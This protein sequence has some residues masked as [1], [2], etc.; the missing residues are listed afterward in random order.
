MTLALPTHA[1]YDSSQVLVTPSQAV[2]R[3]D[4]RFFCAPWFA[5]MGDGPYREAGRPTCYGLRTSPS[6]VLIS[7]EKASTRSPPRMKLFLI[8][9]WA[10]LK[11]NPD[12]S[13]DEFQMAADR[14]ARLAR[15]P[16]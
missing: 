12:A 14:A 2:P 9:I 5:P 1:D 10:F 11:A 13:F 16:E 3:T 15:W 4:K 7:A 8:A 6:R